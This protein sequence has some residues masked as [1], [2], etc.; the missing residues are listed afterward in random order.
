MPSTTPEGLHAALEDAFSR[1]D[2]AA[3]M[4]LHAP[5][6]AVHVPFDGSVA[7]GLDAIRD[8]TAPLVLLRPK[9]T[10]TVLDKVEGTDVALTHA[11]WTLDATRAADGP[12]IP[13]E[14]R[15]TIVSR[16]S[17]DGRWLIVIDDPLT[18]V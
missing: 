13:Q 10:S 12:P 14:G 17:A 1:G 3:F 7:R 2:M 16:R 8:A 6:A 15:G 11:R 4:A 5:D 18:P 9:L